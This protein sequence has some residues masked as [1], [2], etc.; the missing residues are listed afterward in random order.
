M[1]CA[2]RPVPCRWEASR[3]ALRLPPCSTRAAAA[4]S[5]H[6]LSRDQVALV[7]QEAC[8][9]HAAMIK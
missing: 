7:A 3:S 6:N 4:E 8:R 9:L 2:A 5:Y 1:P